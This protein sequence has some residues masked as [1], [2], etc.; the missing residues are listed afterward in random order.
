MFSKG[1]DNIQ[2]RL[3]QARMKIKYDLTAPFERHSMS[4]H[5]GYDSV[6]WT[7]P[8]EYPKP[9]QYSSW[10]NRFF[11]GSYTPKG[12]HTSTCYEVAISST[13]TKVCHMP[14]VSSFWWGEAINITGKLTTS[15]EKHHISFSTPNI[16]IT[17]QLPQDPDFP[18]YHLIKHHPQP[19]WPWTIHS[20]VN[21]KL[22]VAGTLP[23]NVSGFFWYKPLFWAIHYTEYGLILT[24]EK[25]TYKPFNSTYLYP[26]SQSTNLEGLFGF[27]FTNASVPDYIQPTNFIFHP[28]QHV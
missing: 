7:W 24:K 18:M 6:G 27:Q 21:S 28:I 20:S 8:G 26:V 5:A 16:T 9:D 3:E 14:V 13:Y 25:T 2:L 19:P 4:E 15:K 17:S 22:A 23:R 12:K 10:L 11:K 1:A